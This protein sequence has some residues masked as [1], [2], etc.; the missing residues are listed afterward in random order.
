MATTRATVLGANT[1][2]T[3]NV[4]FQD[5]EA[6]AQSASFTQEQKNVLSREDPDSWGLS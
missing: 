2:T 1:V 3:E 4:T 6:P 5:E